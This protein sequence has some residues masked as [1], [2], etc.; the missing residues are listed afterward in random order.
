MTERKATAT[1]RRAKAEGVRDRALGAL[2]EAA[3]ADM[4][5]RVENG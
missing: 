3:Y 5:G 2:I 4:K 1:G